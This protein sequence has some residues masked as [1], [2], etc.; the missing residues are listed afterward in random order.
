MPWAQK[1]ELFEFE[2][3]LGGPLELGRRLGGEDLDTGANPGFR[4]SAG[5]AFTERWGIDSSLFY[6]PSRGGRGRRN[7]RS[8]R[9]RVP[10][11]REG[12]SAENGCSVNRAF[13]QK[14][15]G[16]SGHPRIMKVWL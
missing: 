6:I 2:R 9:C 10:I 1:S 16:P 8:G 4:L 12:G 7:A 13:A 5:Y 11:M 3:R 15:H 14:C